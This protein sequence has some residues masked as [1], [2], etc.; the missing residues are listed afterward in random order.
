[1]KEKPNVGSPFFGSFPSDSIPRRRRMLMCIS[2]FT[3][4]IPV[5]YTSEFWEIYEAATYFAKVYLSKNH[6]PKFQTN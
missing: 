6:S 4:A 1:M 5:N 3:V 2:L